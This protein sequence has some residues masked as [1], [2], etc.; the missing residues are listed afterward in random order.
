MP[1]TERQLAGDLLLDIE[2]D[3]EITP[4]A[5]TAARW[6]NS[7]GSKRFEPIY[8]TNSLFC[9]FCFRDRFGSP[10]GELTRTLAIPAK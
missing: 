5:V 4:N 6:R 8:Q 7:T 2:I 3:I 1:M 10:R 9:I